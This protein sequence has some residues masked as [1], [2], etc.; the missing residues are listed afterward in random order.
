[1]DEQF[2]SLAIEQAELGKQKGDLPFGVVIVQ[3]DQVI[4]SAHAEN[5]TVG[6]VTAH[7]ELLAIRRAC[8]ELG[9]NSLKDCTIYCTNEPC[10]MCAAGIFQADIPR[11]VI[12]AM[13]DELPSLR[14]RK[15]RIDHLADDTGHEI[16]LVKGVLKD[17]VLAV[18][19]Q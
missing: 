17:Q 8:E 4:A 14:P 19:G 12:G 5:N 11:V 3:N 18:H 13:R 15:I 6:D 16:E 1:M 10:I 7:A 9:R 2:M